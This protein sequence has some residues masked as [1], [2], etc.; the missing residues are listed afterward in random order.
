MTLDFHAFLTSSLNVWVNILMVTLLDVFLRKFRYCHHWKSTSKNILSWTQPWVLHKILPCHWGQTF[1]NDDHNN[2]HDKDVDSTQ[3]SHCNN[4]ELWEKIHC[5][6]LT[7]ASFF[8]F[9]LQQSGYFL[10]C[11]FWCLYFSYCWVCVVVLVWMSVKSFTPWVRLDI[12][13][14][15]GISNDGRSLSLGGDSL[16]YML[17][18]IPQ[19]FKWI[20][21][22][23]AVITET[24][25][26]TYCIITVGGS[27]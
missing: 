15:Q 13:L 14:Y 24:E 11:L 7:W 27:L 17:V 19:F 4:M 3:T 8:S 22:D 1:C 23:R 6:F 20:E 26:M 18:A 5:I 25:E 10:L 21:S 16:Q 2:D 12:L 9:W